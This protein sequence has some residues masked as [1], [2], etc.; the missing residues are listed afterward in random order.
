MELIC[1]N[2]AQIKITLPRHPPQTRIKPSDH[3]K[4]HSCQRKP[5]VRW[6]LFLSL[7]LALLLVPV[8]SNYLIQPCAL[9]PALS[10][11]APICL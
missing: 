6:S 8:C 3:F 7:K 2:R 10:F 4:L 5:V 11:D 9:N 1:S